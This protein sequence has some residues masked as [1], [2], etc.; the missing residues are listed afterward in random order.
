MELKRGLNNAVEDPSPTGSVNPIPHVRVRSLPGL[1]G[2][3]IN[4]HD[5]TLDKPPAATNAP[6]YFIVSRDAAGNF[7]W[8]EYKSPFVSAEITNVAF[9]SGGAADAEAFSKTNTT[10][11]VFFDEEE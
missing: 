11:L 2:A 6:A 8:V 10:T 7:A 3:W 5:Y 4:L 9:V 1:P